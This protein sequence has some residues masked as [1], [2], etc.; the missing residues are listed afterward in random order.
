[1]SNNIILP[2][3]WEQRFDPE[4]KRHYYVNHNTKTSHWKIPKNLRYNKRSRSNT[5]T[6]NNIK[7]STSDTINTIKN[8][9]NNNNNNKTKHVKTMSMRIKKNK[10]KGPN[11]INI[12]FND[13]KKK[14]NFVSS[15]SPAPS[16]TKPT[17][18]TSFDS[19]EDIAKYKDRNKPSSPKTPEYNPP[20]YTSNDENKSD[21]DSKNENYNENDSNNDNEI[22]PSVSHT[23]VEPLSLDKKVN[24]EPELLTLPE[25]IIKITS[26]KSRGTKDFMILFH[27]YCLYSS[28][29]FSI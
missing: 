5:I 18:T 2:V 7:Q 16:T 20:I 29:K 3:G 19:L 1:M 23:I 14:G 8:N 22:E 4:T 9:N 10:N 21:D 12:N 27:T 17:H 28:R 26:K 11:T 15:L 13:L 25:I 6:Q 24:D